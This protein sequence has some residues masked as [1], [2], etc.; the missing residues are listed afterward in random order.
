MYL[1][2]SVGFYIGIMILH[3]Q[4]KFYAEIH[5]PFIYGFNQTRGV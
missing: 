5:H 2:F 4:L 3:I 1:W